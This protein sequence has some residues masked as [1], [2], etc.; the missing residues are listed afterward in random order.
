M[1]CANVREHYD[2]PKLDQEFVLFVGC[3][4]KRKNPLTAIRAFFGIANDFPKL[5]LLMIGKPGLGYEDLRNEIQALGLG[6]RVELRENVSAAELS[7]LY[8][9][10][11]FF[12]MPS[13]YEGFGR[14]VIEAMEMGL[15]VV[16]S[17]IAVF[18]E[19]GADAIYYYGAPDNSDSLSKAM[20]S[21][22]GSE[23]MCD[24]LRR[25]GLE[26]CN[27]FSAEKLAIRHLLSYKF[28]RVNQSEYS[29]FERV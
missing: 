15:P 11:S 2:L 17:D 29:C 20:R 10:A 3:V 24:T 13:Y 12:V 22:L 27:E 18:R 9:S 1:C 8:S 5:K 6:D 28:T 25:K 16:A 7:Q 4:E 14:P 23:D 19:I 21:L 26:R